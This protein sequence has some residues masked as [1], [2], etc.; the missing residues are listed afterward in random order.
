M[1]VGMC[2]VHV[3]RPRYTMYA[4]PFLAPLA[5]SACLAPRRPLVRGVLAGLLVLVPLA[6]SIRHDLLLMRPDTRLILS[7]L[8]SS[9]SGAGLSVSVESSL[10]PTFAR[11]PPGVSTF[12]PDMDYRAWLR[13]EATPRQTFVSVQPDVFVRRRDAG[14]R[15]TIS[16]IQLA[17]LGYTLAAPLGAACSF[18]P[19]DPEHVL[20]ELWLADRPGPAVDFWIRTELVSPLRAAFPAVLRRDRSNR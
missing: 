3:A 15:M 12:P 9:L 5:A 16:P 1:L 6:T 4:T 10:M 20:P 14:G 8:A 18:V 2:L 13:G 19:D 7:D 11:R 17:E